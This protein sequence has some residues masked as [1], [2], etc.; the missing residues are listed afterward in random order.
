[1]K[2]LLFAAV[3][4]SVLFASCNTKKTYELSGK[5]E[6]QQEGKIYLNIE[7]D[8][9]LVKI[10]SADIVN[11]VFKLEGNVTVPDVCYLQVGD[12]RGAISIFLENAPITV[13]ANMDNLR[14]AK[15]TG[16]A[17]QDVYN[18]FEALMAEY[19][20]KQEPIIAVYKKAMADKDE[21]AAEK[22][23]KEYEA[24]DSAK[25]A[26]V[27]TFI[28]DN[29]TSVAASVIAYRS[30]LSQAEV[31]EM[32]AI[33][34]AFSEDVKAARSSVVIKSRLDIL[35]SVAVGQ[36]APDFTLNTPEGT[37]LSL[38][39]LKGKVVVI[40]FWASWCGPCRRANP[41]MVEMYNE[42]SSKGVEFLGV[43]LDN[44]E[45]KWLKAIED[46]GL[47]WKHVSD[48]KGWDSA[49][50]KLYGVNSIPATVLID[51]DGIIVAQKI[52]GDKLKAEIEKLLK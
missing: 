27:K 1:M 43:S 3:A 24:I 48:L 17:S 4:I 11:G 9:K 20:T 8:R 39:S 28:K 23:V 41:H 30:L 37:P 18:S 49:A 45:A 13:E 25:M 14:E 22:A 12:K 15:I 33:Y 36:P 19:K 29:S 7:Q 38:S 16:S 21:V 40:D 44:D 34:N 50:A 42:L 6:G 10:D 26:S 47:I 32:E 2:K 5:I 52:S 31:S 35:K 46:D 51:K